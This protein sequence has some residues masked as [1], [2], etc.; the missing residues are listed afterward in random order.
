MRIQVPVFVRGKDAAGD[1]FLELTRTVNISS[2]GAS[3]VSPRPL[4]MDE[5]VTLTVP[6]PSPASARATVGP[7]PTI[8]ARVRRLQA[9]GEDNLVGVEFLRPLE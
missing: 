5:M 4:R 2:T 1:E 7:N 9:A 6:A 8:Q 3:I